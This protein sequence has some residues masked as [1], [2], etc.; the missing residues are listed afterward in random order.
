MTHFSFL[1]LGC[2]LAIAACTP[3]PAGAP[4][5]TADPLSFPFQRDVESPNSFPRGASTS[6]PFAAQSGVYGVTR[7][8]P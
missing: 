1:C 4:V 6:T 3:A 5:T 7:T 8:A 2:L